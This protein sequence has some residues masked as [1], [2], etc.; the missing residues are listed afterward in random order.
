MPDFVRQI[1]GP[2]TTTSPFDPDRTE[3]HYP[4][5]LEVE[6]V[7][8]DIDLALDLVAQTAHGVV[9][10]SVEA[11]RNG[12]RTLTLDAVELEI[13]SVEDGDGRALTWHADGRQLVITWHQPFGIRER[14]RVAVRYAVGR[15]S[16]GLYFSRPT[17]LDP[18]MPW[19]AVTDHETERARYWLP[20]IDLPNVRTSLDMRLRADARFTIL[21]NGY[22][23][24][25]QEH[26]DG[27]RTDHWRLEERCPSYLICFAVGEFVRADDGAY[28]D[29][30][31]AIPVA[32]FCS[33][34]HTSTD[35]LRSFDRTK[36]MLAWMTE[37]FGLSF[38]YPKYYQWAAPGIS[39][40]M[41]NISLVSW[42]EKYV[43]DAVLA[44]EWT[45]LLDTINIHEMA[46]SYFGD[47][48]V[49]RDFAHAWLKESWATYIEQVWREDTGSMDE[50]LYV[51][52]QHARN[53]FE[54][55]DN[56]YQRPIV[57][58][59]YQSSWDLY[60]RHLYPGG[61]CRLHTLRQELGDETFWSALRD[62]L[63]RYAGKVVETDDFRLEMEEY[64]GRSLGRFF[65]QWFHSP[66]YPNLAIKFTY[67]EEEGQG[68]FEVEQR[69]ADN[70]KGI[71]AFVLN[72]DISWYIDG[73]AS[74][75]PVR[76]EQARQLFVFTMPRRPD[77]IVFDPLCKVLHKLSF[78]P[79]DDL[80]RRQLS[81]G[82]T[83]LARIHAAQEL[84]RSGRQAN[85]K[86]VVAAYR[87][88][89]FWGVRVEM[90]TAL[91][92]ANHEVAVAGLAG[93]IV[94]ERHPLVMPAVFRAAS[95]Y[96]DLRLREAIEARLEQGLPYA[97]TQAAYEALGAQRDQ[98][99]LQLL[100][101][102]AR[103]PSFNGVAQ[104]GAVRGLAA[105]RREEALPILL[106]L[107][108]PGGSTIYVRPAAVSALAE[109]AKALERRGRAQAIE[110]LVDLLRDPAYQVALAAVR[111]L[112]A[113]EATEAIAALEMFARGRARQESVVALRV[114]DELRRGKR[115]D[116]SLQN[117]V[118]ELRE[119]VRKLQDDVDRLRARV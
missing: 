58:R 108:R 42:D 114:A 70:D 36:P 35:L 109:L 71:P 11:R 116:A 19:Y 94:D 104:I 40:A 93:I 66:G 62:Y 75:Q 95:N 32:Y 27:T 43:L 105:T 101:E 69:Q 23:A 47:A 54:E 115:P 67:E 51:Y 81:A 14:R 83:V 53:Y 102:A 45:W 113:M 7:H 76:I 84:A 17:D 110:A 103:R 2:G 86:A 39:G 74:T 85:L 87:T 10:I 38:P 28:H 48:V 22:L 96:R 97:A 41:E 44:T 90:A 99:P 72:T 20:C 77:M 68:V 82:S 3:A 106:E 89:A 88:E 12:V 92:K 117:Q 6:P 111:G 9:T 59:H 60:D 64:S 46:H 15:P 78:N 29:G 18:T 91:G 79:G 8:L 50:A 56:R 5:D 119:R 33:P 37:K 107:V 30:E 24:D 21:A 63:A 31:K 1:Y 100:A 118:E 13:D 65:D 80:L 98:A 34:Q 73:Q 61:A 112:G 57:T 4:P 26:D 16:A 52:Y 49:C 25:Q 55:A